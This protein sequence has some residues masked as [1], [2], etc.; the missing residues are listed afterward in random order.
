[1]ETK[2]KTED[3]QANEDNELPLPE[4]EN[5]SEGRQVQDFSLSGYRSSSCQTPGASQNDEFILPHL[6][7]KNSTVLNDS[8]DKTST[9]SETVIDRVVAK[10]AAAQAEMLAEINM[11]RAV[12]LKAQDEKGKE[13][14]MR[15]RFDIPVVRIGGCSTPADHSLPCT[16]ATPAADYPFVN[17]FAKKMEIA[18]FKGN[19]SEFS[20]FEQEFKLYVEPSVPEDSRRYRILVQLCEGDARM[21][22]ENCS[23]VPDGARYHKAMSHLRDIYGRV[24][25]IASSVRINS[26]GKG[27]L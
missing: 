15:N 21:A 1:M 22:V 7:P 9:S 24:H 14:E 27:K 25:M 11:L 12:R 23:D 19:I 13:E 6:M 2:R 20:R 17:P 4:E 26:L 3:T 16:S 5:Q 18:P 10:F 8:S